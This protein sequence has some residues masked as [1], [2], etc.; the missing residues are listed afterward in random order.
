MKKRRK[1]F[2]LKQVSL[3][4]ICQKYPYKVKSVQSRSND[5]VLHLDNMRLIFT[6][7]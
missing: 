3:G 5:T 7:K 2:R 1:R 6:K 4:E